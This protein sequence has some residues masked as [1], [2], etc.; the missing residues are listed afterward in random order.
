MTASR[1]RATLPLLLVGL[2]AVAALASVLLLADGRNPAHAQ[3]PVNQS[4]TGAPVVLAS[5]EGVPVLFADTSGIGDPNGIAFTGMEEAVVEFVYSYQWIRVHGAT[6]AQTV[7]GSDSPRYEL[8]DADV[9]SIIKVEVSFIDGDGFSETVTSLPFGP[10]VEPAPLASASTLVANTAQAHSA[11]AM[12]DKQ[13]AMEFTLGPHGQGYEISGVSIE[14]AAA[15]SD[16]TVS[17]WIGNHSGRSSTSPRARLFDFENPSSLVAGTNKFTAP[18]GVLAYPG[19]HYYIVLTGFGSSLSIKETT[20]DDEDEGAETGVELGDSACERALAKT[21][22]WTGS[23]SRANVVRLAVE[24]SRRT[25]GILISTYAQPVANDQEVISIG[26]SCCFEMG[27]GD[28]DR[29]LIRGFSW[30]SDDTTSNTGGITNPWDLRDGATDSS[31]KLFK[32]INTRNAAGITEWTAPQGATVPGGTGKTYL[33]DQDFVWPSGLDPGTR[34]G[35]ALTRIFGTEAG[36]TGSDT[37]TTPGITISAHGDNAINQPMAAVLGVPLYAMTQNLGRTDNGYVSV[38]DTHKV[39]SQAF[40]TGPDPDGY[41]LQGFGINIEG[42]DSKFPDSQASVSAAVHADTDGKPGTK[43]FDLLSPTEYGAGHSFLEAPPRTTLDP[44]T[45]YVLVWTHNNGT[46]HRLVKTAADNEDTGARTGFAIANTLYQGA[47]PDNMAQDPARNALQIAVYSRHQANATGTPVV[48]ASAEDPGVLAVDTSGIG[49]PDGIPNVGD[50]NTTGILHNFS[51]RWIRIDG[52][53]ETTVGADSADYRQ[54][55]KELHDSGIRIESGRYRR[56]DADVGKLLKVEVSFTDSFGFVESVTSGPFGPVPRPARSPSASTLVANTAQ[57]DSAT[58]T[59]SGRYDMGFEL[60]SHGQ[61]YE[62]SGVSIELAAVPSSLTV[63]LWMGLAPGSGDAGAR[64]KLFD[65]ENPSSFAV[66]LNEFTA[67]TGA[68]AY[69]GVDYFVV[70]SDFG[71][72]LSIKVTTSDNEDTGG[73]TGATLADTAGGDTNVLRLAVKGSQR[74]GGILVSTYAQVADIQENVSVGDNLG[75][76][77]TVG[78]ADRYL[79]RGASFSGDNTTSR[80]GVYTAPWDLRDGTDELFSMVSTR[81][82]SG[83]N[84]WT[85]PQGATVAGG[86]TTDAMTMMETCE[87]YN[88]YQQVSHPVTGHRRGGVV[89]SRYFGTTSTAEDSPK[90]TGVSIGNATDDF[91]LTTPL[92]AVFGEALDA[93]AQNLGQSDNGYV[94]LGAANARVASQGFTTGSDEFGYRLQGIGVNIEGSGSQFPDG[95]TSVSVAVHA[96]SGGKPGGK[97]FDLASPTEFAAGHSF[98]E[99]PPETQ[100][101]PD[102]AYVLVWS[103]RD[104]T[105]HRL[106]RTSNDGEDSGALTG[107]SIADAYYRGAGLTSLS[108]N[109]GGNSLEIAVYGEANTETPR[110]PFVEGGHPVTTSWLHI[111]DDADVGY[112]FRLVFVTHRATLPAPGDIEAYNAFVREEAAGTHVRGEPVGDTTAAEPYTD[113]VIRTVADRFAAVV[114]TASV[115]A[116]SNTEMPII[117]IGVAIHWLDGGWQDRPTL[118]ADSYDTFYGGAWVNTDYGAYVTGNSAYFHENA[119]VWTG[120][121]ASGAADPLYP[122]GAASPMGLVAVGTPNDPAANNAPIGAVD[123]SVGRVTASIYGYRPLYAISPIFT[124]VP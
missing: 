27:V 26:D 107:F 70:L 116:R 71:S 32:L 34:T 98:F 77:F 55:N 111:P 120:C 88:F 52:D 16:L 42:S 14:L 96:D 6:A 40:T 87:E 57:A 97:L 17:L 78:G 81:Q 102:T 113:P 8:V 41:Q 86:C 67:P 115:D 104:G 12:I 106:Q 10:V 62:I 30:N 108:K 79:I 24:G 123:A 58:A 122:M 23:C 94:S 22:R 93:M 35:A 20:S 19:V 37:P 64:T 38:G 100:L 4:A 15:P 31:A 68:F 5:A 109:S 25:S 50:Q 121:D 18:A 124:V 13:Y 82:I 44:S 29:Y 105:W 110:P 60:G 119:M 53:T 54:I 91:A 48:L 103:Y 39:L 49:D 118:I 112:Q 21:G 72:P 95:P 84:E 51:Y 2:G 92:M 47:D 80:A 75:V 66:G 36:N 85:A 33:F 11:T 74:N 45:P 3:T 89:L 46:A 73:E 65:F 1:R 56:V 101:K 43:L 83:I 7:V 76:E 63:S 90:A 69:Q 117:E 114:C 9:G 99:A 59:I 61:G 28:A